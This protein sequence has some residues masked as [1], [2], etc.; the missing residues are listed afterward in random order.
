V[1][2]IPSQSLSQLDFDL[3]AGDDDVQSFIETDT[4]AVNILVQK[5]A[6]RLHR[7]RISTI[8]KMKRMSL[9]ASAANMQLHLPSARQSYYPVPLIETTETVDEDQEILNWASLSGPLEK[10]L[11]I[12]LSYLSE[13]DLMATAFPVCKAWSD[14]ATIAHTKLLIASVKSDDIVERQFLSVCE[15]PILERSWT[16]LHD[17]FPW[18]C[19]LAEG[20]AKKVYKVFN[21]SVNEEEALSVMYVYC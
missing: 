2:P 13:S 18:A 3:E 7:K 21:S 14:Y 16:F 11:P 8:N 4:E 5:D 19:F 10:I 15:V 17:R 9:F 12:I 1:Y 6:D 20:G